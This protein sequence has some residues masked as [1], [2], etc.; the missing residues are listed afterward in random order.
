MRIFFPSF[1]V[2]VIGLSLDFILSCWGYFSPSSSSI[3]VI[4][5]WCVGGVLCVTIFSDFLLAELV[6]RYGNYPKRRQL[7]TTYVGGVLSAVEGLFSFTGI[8]HWLWKR[9]EQRLKTITSDYLCWRSPFCSW[10]T[11]FGRLKTVTSDYLWWR[12]PLGSWGT[13]FFYRNWSFVTEIIR[14]KVKER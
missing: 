11:I 4:R 1:Y 5:L 12:S 3:F 2:C 13:I 14:T 6:L 9:S 8:G 7:Q 10:G